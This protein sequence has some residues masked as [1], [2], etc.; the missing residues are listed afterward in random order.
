MIALFQQG[1]FVMWPLFL[2]AVAAFYLI[3]L[4]GFQLFKLARYYK[5]SSVTEEVRN[6]IRDQHFKQATSLLTFNGPSEKILQKGVE[7]LEAR[8]SEDAI[9]DRLEVIYDNEIHE[10]ESGLSTLLILGEI[11]PMLGLLGTVS[12][13]IHVFKAITAYGAG[14]AQALAGGISEALLTTEVGLVLAIPTMF[15]YT[16]LQAKVDYLAK[17]MRYS[18]SMVVIVSRLINKK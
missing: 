1:G 2:V 6:A 13:M 9:R 3:F 14:D 4:K 8:F 5:K 7:Y 18:G 12:G 17:V 15:C 16:L 11:M 10:L